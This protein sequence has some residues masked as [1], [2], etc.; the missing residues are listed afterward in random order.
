[1]GV[2]LGSMG[3]KGVQGVQGVQGGSRGVPPFAFYK[4]WS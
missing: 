2:Q 1:M 3:F 4:E